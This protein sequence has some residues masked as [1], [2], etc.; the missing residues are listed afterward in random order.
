MSHK[1]L[2]CK[3]N[4]IIEASYRLTLTEQRIILFAIGQVNSQD[5]LNSNNVFKI[6]ASEY[7]SLF[8]IDKKEAFREMKEAMDILSERWVKVIVSDDKI[9]SIRWISKKSTTLSE[10]CIE[11]RF[12]ADI[13]PYL[14]NLKG[15][16]TKYQLLNISGMKSIFSIRIYEMLM[17][18]KIKRSVTLKV[19]Q[20]RDRLQITTAGYASFGNIKQKII[21]PAIKEINAC[22]DI[23]ADYEL[24]RKGNKIVSVK[25]QYRFKPGMEPKKSAVKQAKQAVVNQLRAAL[26]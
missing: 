8:G 12:T 16:F 19:E 7:S 3:D 17:Q 11:V 1:D 6:N 10:Q 26:I 25:F 23:D 21:D 24:T 20:L 14:S 5:K 15:S 4:R 9:D 13:A 22:S 18:W 2:V